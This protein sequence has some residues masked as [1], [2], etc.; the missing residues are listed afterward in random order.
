MTASL[1]KRD[2]IRE[3]LI[4]LIKARAVG[5][6]IPAE[7]QLCVELETSRP[8]LR[9]VVDELVRDGWLVREHGRGVFV[10]TPKI[11]QE[12]VTG[13]ASNQT[14][15][16][17]APGKWTSRVID[18]SIVPAGMSIGSRL[19]VEAAT[20]V[21]RIARQRL[22]DDEPMALETIHVLSDLVPGA[23]A[24]DVESGSFYSLL[25]ERYDLVPTAAEQTHEA[26]A[27]DAVQASLLGIGEG[28]PVLSLERV[29][30]DQH[31]RLFEYTRA[32]YRGDRYR[33]VSHLTLVGPPDEAA[34]RVTPTL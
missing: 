30:R 9:A 3:H 29:T 16:P 4:A 7:R 19:R 31:G 11:A 1:R 10:G 15:Y 5:Q 34:P 2:R 13:L 12:I 18:H 33:L 21:L 6:A 32:V 27:A 14:G 8:T 20:P 28:A 23:S 25:R 22:V 17:P 24:G 26:T